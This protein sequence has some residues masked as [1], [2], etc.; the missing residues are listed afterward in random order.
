AALRPLIQP[1]YRLAYGMLHD[2][3]AAEDAVQEAALKAWRKRSNLRPGAPMRPW[4]LAIVANESRSVRR[5]RWWS[6]IKLPD[7][8][9][10]AEFPEDKLSEATTIRTA[11][12]RLDHKVRLVIVLHF[13]LDL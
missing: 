10:R 3:P 5:S 1:A 12:R 9:Q 4:F 8:P 11:L 6:V 7:L 2:R 13:Y